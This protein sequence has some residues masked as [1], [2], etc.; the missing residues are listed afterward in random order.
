MGEQLLKSCL[1]DEWIRIFKNHKWQQT[2]DKQ[3]YYADLNNV[4]HSAI[5]SININSYMHFVGHNMPLFSKLPNFPQKRKHG[6]WKH[7]CL[8]SSREAHRHSSCRDLP[9]G[10]W[11]QHYTVATEEPPP[12]PPSQ[13]CSITQCFC[14][15]ICP[16]SAPV[17]VLSMPVRAQCLQRKDD[18]FFYLSKLYFWKLYSI[19]KA[20]VRH[21][22]H[23][24]LY[25]ILS[26]IGCHLDRKFKSII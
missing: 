13:L 19:F 4:E 14:P 6:L 18:F 9:A 23:V 24:F 1:R 17:F 3:N 5:T 2:T 22:R 8:T 25:V 12:L 21:L 7:P 16:H 15:C 10:Q 20:T 11:K 26:C